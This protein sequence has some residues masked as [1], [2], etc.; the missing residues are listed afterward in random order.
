MF[1]KKLKFPYLHEIQE[2]RFLAENFSPYKLLNSKNVHQ[3]RS[4]W[5]LFWLKKMQAE[6]EVGN[7]RFNVYS[8]R[9]ICRLIMSLLLYYLVEPEQ[10]TGW[11]WADLPGLYTWATWPCVDP[12]LYELYC[13]VILLFL[14]CIMHAEI[15]RG[16]Q[17][18]FSVFI[19]QNRFLFVTHILLGILSTFRQ[20][21]TM[22]TQTV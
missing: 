21:K 9:Y 5:T 16:K 11:L 8:C 22:L 10:C 1:L 15:S 14:P 4:F 20:R 13:R 19:K 18:Y 12:A 6:T 7:T 17:K 3:K 2:I